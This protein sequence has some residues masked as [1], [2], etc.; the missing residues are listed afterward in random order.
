M[1]KILAEL[2]QGFIHQGHIPAADRAFKDK[3]QRYF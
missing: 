1:S 2:S 3:G